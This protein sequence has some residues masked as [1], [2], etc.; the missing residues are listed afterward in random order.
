M[1]SR[2]RRHPAGRAI[3]ANR[4]RPALAL[5]LLAA[6]AAGLGA[7]S[8]LL[9]IEPGKSTRADAEKVFGPSTGETTA[10]A[11]AYAP[12]GG[13]A[14]IEIA[15][16]ANGIVERIELR[17]APGRPK[18]AAARE[19]ALPERPDA[20][21]ATPQSQLVEYYGGSRTL[22]VTHETMEPG[23][24]VVGVGYY[25]RE[26]FERVTAGLIAAG[27]QGSPSNAVRLAN[28]KDAPV[29][30]QFNP[31]A[32]SDVYF[33]AQNEHEAARKSRNAAR[34]QAILEVMITAQRGDCATARA[35]ADRYK[36]TYR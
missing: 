36:E 33:W 22:V 25:S 21:A 14:G 18:P 26:L 17:F 4:M 11:L 28:P 10:G 16:R 15:Y 1:T 34:R 2:N 8:V 12:R 19:L 31:G 24:A 6:A 20:T 5:L 23:S 30:Q 13:A 9:G 3:A 32:C 35:Q 27:Q 29:I 7:V